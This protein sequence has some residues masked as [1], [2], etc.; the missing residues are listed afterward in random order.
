MRVTR[1]KRKHLGRNS[2]GISIFYRSKYCK[3]VN[4]CKS[5]SSDDIVWVVFKF[6]HLK[7]CFGV[8]YFSPQGSSSYS[9]QQNFTILEDELALYSSKFPNF[10]F[11]ICGDFNARTANDPDYVTD[12]TNYF[13]PLGDDYLIDNDIS[14]RT[15]RDE[16]TNAYGQLLLDFCKNTQMRIINGRLFDDRDKGYFTYTKDTGG[17]VIDYVL[18]DKCNFDLFSHF[19]VSDERA[20]SDH[21]PVLF[22]LKFPLVTE[23]GNNS[24]TLD[25]ETSACTK[26]AWR[27]SHRESFNLF[28]ENSIGRRQIDHFHLLLETD[29]SGAASVLIDLIQQSAKSMKV[30]PK[31]SFI[32]NNGNS[33]G[34]QV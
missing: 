31:T 25:S 14:V 8:L 15:S 32:S 27:D 28:W 5:V 33:R 2:G 22:D 11:I 10:D 29:T 24:S 12:D 4:I 34:C 26:Y 16:T 13:V 19:C 23:S 20:E 1:S 6:E 3:C 7:L 17:S 9:D 30:T 18:A 21:H